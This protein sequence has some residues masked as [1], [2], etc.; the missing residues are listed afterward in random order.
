[1]RRQT[2]VAADRDTR[3]SR[4]RDASIAQTAAYRFRTSRE[5]DDPHRLFGRPL[6]DILTVLEKWDRIA[7]RFAAVL[8]ENRRGRVLAQ[9]AAPRF[10]S[11]VE[12]A[13][14]EGVAGEAD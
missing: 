13:A 12:S 8:G 5:T 2:D 3:P 10:L 14:V 6:K 9:I 1:M 7:P 4:A 11:R